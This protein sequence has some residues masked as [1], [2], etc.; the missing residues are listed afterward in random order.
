MAFFDTLIVLFQVFVVDDTVL[1]NRGF[2]RPLLSTLEG[3]PTSVIYSHT[4]SMLPARIYAYSED[5]KVH[6]D[7]QIWQETSLGKG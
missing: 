4:D 6:A 5:K 3:N 7:E 1:V 2:I